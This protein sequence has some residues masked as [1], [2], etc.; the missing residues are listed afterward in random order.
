MVM[1]VRWFV[2][3]AP[4]SGLPQIMVAPARRTSRSEPQ[5]SRRVWELGVTRIVTRVIT[6]PQSSPDMRYI[7]Q[8]I[9]S[10]VGNNT[11]SLRNY[12]ALV[13]KALA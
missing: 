1:T 5:I 11:P 13:S 7:L 10:L 9:Y 3:A 2:A 4:R 6:R 8:S 12:G